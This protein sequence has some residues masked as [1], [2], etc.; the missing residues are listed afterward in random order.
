MEKIHPRAS[1]SSNF[2]MSKFTH[3]ASRGVRQEVQVVVL[4][5]ALRSRLSR[6]WVSVFCMESIFLS[7]ISAARARSALCSSVDSSNIW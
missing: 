6:S 3:L 7:V 5:I 2:G 1:V 4:E